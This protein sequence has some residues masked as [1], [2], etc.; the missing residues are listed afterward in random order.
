MKKLL[1]TIMVGAMCLCGCGSEGNNSEKNESAKSSEQKEQEKQEDVMFVETIKEAPSGFLYDG[2]QKENLM[3]SEIGIYTLEDL[4][5]IP[6]N[7]EET[8]VLMADIDCGGETLNIKNFK[9]EFDGN[10]YHLQNLKSPVFGTVYDGKI[11]NLAV[12]DSAAASA[13]IASCL[14]SGSIKNCYV[15]GEIGKDTDG[16]DPVGGIV[17]E[18]LATECWIT[19]CYN[20]ADIYGGTDAGGIVGEATSNG[21]NANAPIRIYSCENYGNVYGSNNGGVGGICG[22]LF[23]EK[24]QSNYS[25]HFELS[26]CL[27]YGTIS[28]SGESSNSPVDIGGIVGNAYVKTMSKNAEMYISIGY[29]ANYGRLEVSEDLNASVGGICGNM[30]N[31]TNEQ[32]DVRV[33][34]VGCLNSSASEVALAGGVDPEKGVVTL[35]QCINLSQHASSPMYTFM[36]QAGGDNGYVQVLDCCYLNYKGNS[37]AKSQEAVG[38]TKEEMQDE[39]SFDYGFDDNW[40]FSEDKNNGYPYMMNEEEYSEYIE[41]AIGEYEEQ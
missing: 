22:D 38:L 8:Y 36:N 39:Q 27:N 24:S 26:G 19:N 3:E 28:M 30:E 17:A 1:A 16:F 5:N 13:G 21:S 20:A 15:T 32:S 18:V 41:S 10:F 2:E 29:S 6:E 23:F 33:R 12:I 35:E 11:S 14:R 34:M 31:N 37:G 4:K 25:G 40:T 9:G 7:A